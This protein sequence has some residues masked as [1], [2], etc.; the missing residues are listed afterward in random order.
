MYDPSVIIIMSVWP[1]YLVCNVYDLICIVYDDVSY[2]LSVT[3]VCSAMRAEY[4][5]CYMRKL[6]VYCL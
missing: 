1:L 4:L 2:I 5:C 3:H 6:Y